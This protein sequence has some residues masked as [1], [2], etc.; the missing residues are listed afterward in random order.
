MYN[1]GASKEL[2]IALREEEQYLQDGVD[3]QETM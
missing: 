1:M 3:E 2:F